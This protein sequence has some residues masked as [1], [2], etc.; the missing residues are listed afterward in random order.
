MMIRYLFFSMLMTAVVAAGSL[1]PTI[2]G[3][4]PVR[5]P[6]VAPVMTASEEAEIDALADR[7][8]PEAFNRLKDPAIR[9][10]KDVAYVAV[11]RIFKHRRTEAVAYAERILQGPLTE[12]AAGRKISRGN[13]FSVATKV[14][15][16]FPEE[17]AERLPSLYG[18]SDGITRGNIVRAAGGVDGGTP[19]ESLLTTAL[20]DNTDAE[21]ASL[22]DSGPP[23]RVCDLAY[24][25][26][27]LRHQIRDV[28]R[29]ISPGHRIEVRDH[30]IAILK[31]RLQTRSR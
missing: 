31:E 1:A 15:E 11:E 2:A 27:V 8:I 25:Q 26:L 6:K 18:K 12:V 5:R 4:D 21:T 22:E 14:F 29:T 7:D 20:D 30:H 10:K 17:A 19:I 24:N 23:L 16:V 13:D 9:L 3:A 28:L